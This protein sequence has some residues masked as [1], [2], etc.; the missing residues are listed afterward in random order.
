MS[1]LPKV[2]QTLFRKT[3]RIERVNALMYFPIFYK[4]FKLRI[5]KPKSIMRKLSKCTAKFYSNK[6]LN[7]FREIVHD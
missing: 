4:L 1:Q 2:P 6:T 3:L 5:N 7:R